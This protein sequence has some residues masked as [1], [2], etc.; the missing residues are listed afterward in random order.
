MNN[1]TLLKFFTFAFI[2]IINLFDIKGYLVGVDLGSEFFKATMLRPGRPF[3]MVENIQSKT[4]TPTSVALKDDERVFGADATV[5]KPRLP[6]GVLTF[7]HEYLGKKHSSEEVKNFIERFFVA[8]D[9]EEDQERGTTTFKITFNKEEFKFSTEEVYGMLFR[10]IKYLADKFSQSD[11]KDCVVTVPAFFGYR[12]RQALAQA[13]EMS[14]LNLLGFVSENVA[15]AVQFSMNKNFNST[16]YYI[17]YNMGS[18]YT[19]ATLVSFLS[20]MQTKN[21]KTVEVSKTL[22]VLGETWDK[23]LGGN[24]F[25]FNLVRHLMKKFDELPERKDK[26]SVMN[27]YKVAER[28]LP[29]AVRYKEILSANK[30]VPVSILSVDSGMNLKTKL[31]REEFEEINK[32]DFEKVYNPIEKLLNRTGVTLDKINQIELLGGSIRIPKIQE[33]LKLKLGDYSNILGTHMNG[34]DSMAFG[35]AYVC[36]NYSSN[37]KGAKI[38]L[39]HG[40]NYEVK[41]KLSHIQN[42]TETLCADNTTTLADNCVRKLDKTTILYKLRYGL[43]LARTVSFKHDSDLKVELF[44]KFEDSEE[45]LVATYKL[46]GMD[47]MRSK[48]KNEKLDIMPKVNLRFKQDGKGIISL[49]ADSSYEQVLYLN[50]KE[51]PNGGQEVVYLPFPTSPLPEEEIKKYQE[52]LKSQNLTEAARKTLLNMRKDVGK[53]KTQEEKVEFNIVTEYTL[54]RPLTKEEIAQSKLKLD[55]LD[56]MDSNRIKT[57]EKRNALETLIYA[58]KEW[59]DSKEAAKVSKIGE[60]EE[61]SKGLNSISEWYEDEGYNAVFDILNTKFNELNDKFKVFENRMTRFHK[62][63]ASIENFDKEM[64]KIRSDVANL[65]KIK[66]WV[67]THFNNTFSKEIKS[68]EDWFAENK[69]KQDKLALHEVL[70]K[71]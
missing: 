49:K 70:L 30:E 13:V 65:L 64:K 12:Q 20:N 55:K 62:R 17:F 53:K 33:N 31:T 37:F 69:E 6:K 7:F 32:N 5:K 71:I 26:P 28:I 54:P 45:K 44:E 52:E 38:E 2:A 57:M 58:K 63:E 50:L 21:N 42:E 40:A 15:A 39:Y 4:K 59:L 66:P 18:S 22:N 25:N 16:E 23:D 27:D 67:E 47:K 14:R 1:I 51:G 10:Y 29:G 41:I 3:T 48:L 68:V 36:A 61:A 60:L 11:I 46:T 56:L 9:M 24:G 35:A 8:Y 19:Q 34:D 43:D